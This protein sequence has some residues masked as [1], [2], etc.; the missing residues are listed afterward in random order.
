MRIGGTFVTTMRLSQTYPLDPL[1]LYRLPYVRSECS[2]QPLNGRGPLAWLSRLVV[3]GSEET[4]QEDYHDL[5][6]RSHPFTRIVCHS[7][8]VSHHDERTLQTS[9][10]SI[11]Y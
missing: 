6:N 3:V 4:H 2:F 10:W 5:G 9:P 8:H 1:A 11:P 7:R